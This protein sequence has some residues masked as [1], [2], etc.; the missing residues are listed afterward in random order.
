[1]DSRADTR[2]DDL[3][4]PSL[5]DMGYELVRVQLSGSERRTLQIMAERVDGADMTVEDCASISRAVSA[6]LDVEDPIRGMY[7]LEVSSPGIDRPLTRKKDFERFAGHRVRVELRR[8]IDGRKRYNGKIVGVT[9]DMLRLTT[10]QGE[11]EVPVM[12]IVA[13]KLILTDDLI[14]ASQGGAKHG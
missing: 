4:E 14:E 7:T 10:D 9:A 2:I 3:I 11:V 1:M 5:G 13:A 6:I 12:E 8:L